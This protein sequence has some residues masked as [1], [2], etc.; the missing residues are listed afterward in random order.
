MIAS[1]P[2]PPA[3]RRRPGCS[4]SASTQ[5]RSAPTI[6][7]TGSG[8][9]T[10]PRLSQRE[11]S[12]PGRVR[13]SRHGRRTRRAA[14]YSRRSGQGHR[15]PPTAGGLGTG[16]GSC[17]A[18][19]VT[20]SVGRCQQEV[21]GA[22][23][24][25]R[26][27]APR[28]TRVRCAR[29]SGRIQSRARPGPGAHQL[30][31]RVPH[32]PAPGRGRPAAATAARHPGHEIVGR[33][34]ATGEGASR[35]ALG[36][37]V[38]VAVAG[39]HRRHLRI[40]PPRRR[41]PLPAPRLHRLGHRRR[42]CGRLR[43]RRGATCTGCPT[44]S[45]TST[46]LRCCAPASSATARCVRAEVPA[47]G[48]L[49]IYGFG[50]SAHITAQVALRQGLRVHVLTRGE[51]NRRLARRAGRRLG[52]RRGRRSR[53]SRSTARSCSRPAG[54]L[55]PLALRALDR[56][57][58]LAIAG[59]WL[60]DIPALSYADELFEERQVR[61]VTANT[62]AGRRGVPGAGRPARHPADDQS[63]T[64]WPRAAGAGRPG[65]RPLQRRRRP[66]Q[67][68]LADPQGKE[69]SIAGARGARATKRRRCGAG[70]IR[71]TS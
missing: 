32:R 42:L 60:S 18:E 16:L 19:L 31:R 55:V 38:G 24:G 15:R 7:V 20:S 56:G 59:I 63:A 25:C 21:S 52:R 13:G 53:P 65:P 22:G 36:D 28:L 35:F 51:G 2:R 26:T 39:Q 4:P 71:A 29:S 64:R 61:S 67:L 69:A 34:E 48:R 41:E 33:V 68:G 47:G 5:S 49:G 10:H 70:R 17:R 30:L 6:W 43:G 66:A 57:G 27:S 50:G 12:W 44:S 8:Q 62:R 58:T 23:L 54:E 9:L 40:L 37:R 3:A 1:W 45:M 46:P 11:V 14:G